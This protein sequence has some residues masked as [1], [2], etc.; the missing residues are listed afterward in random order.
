MTGM[1]MESKEVC[2][3]KFFFAEI[4]DGKV[5]LECCSCGR[6]WPIGTDG[7]LAPSAR[8]DMNKSRTDGQ[9]RSPGTALAI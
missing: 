3:G 6:I 4:V 9:Q 7:R 2:C 1:D 5:V 8:L